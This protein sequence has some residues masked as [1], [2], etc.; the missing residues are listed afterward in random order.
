MNLNTLP[1]VAARERFVSTVRN[2]QVTILVG[3]TGS[4]KTILGPKMLHEA[5]LAPRGQIAVTEPRR[6]AVTS[7]TKFVRQQF[8]HSTNFGFQIR[9]VVDRRDDDNIVYMTTG[10]MLRE[11][12][13]DPQLRR[14]QIIFVDEAHERSL[15]SDLLLG[16]LKKV[17]DQDP[18]LKVVVASATIDA[19]KFSTFFGGA[20]IVEVEGFNFPVKIHYSPTNYNTEPVEHRVDGRWE[21]RP[22]EY[23]DV[24]VRR[25]QYVCDSS[26]EGDI[27][28]F[29]PGVKEINWVEAGITELR[30]PNIR[31][32]HMHGNLPVEKQNEAL[33]PCSARKI[34]IATN[35]AETS[36]TPDGLTVIIDSGLVKQEELENTWNGHQVAAL[37]VVEHSQAGCDQRAGRAG[38]TA[39][40]EC[41]RLFT[42]SSFKSRPKYT[43]PEIHRTPIENTLLHL[44]AIGEGDIEHFPF[45][46]PPDFNRVRDTLELLFELGAIDKERHLTPLGAQMAALPL[47]PRIAK[48]VLTAQKYNCLMEATILAAFLSTNRSVYI[49]AKDENREEAERAWD[50]VRDR[51]SDYMSY[52]KI[53]RLWDLEPDEVSQKNWCFNH[54]L[55]HRALVEVDMISDQICDLLRDI[56]IEVEPPA[57]SDSVISNP[58]ATAIHKCVLAA[59]AHNAM[60]STGRS[61]Y[62]HPAA[63]T[64]HIHRGSV[65]YRTNTQYVIAA[66]IGKKGKEVYGEQRTY[67][68]HVAPFKL[69]WIEEVAPHL[70]RP[71]INLANLEVNLSTHDF[72][73]MVKYRFNGVIS[74]GLEDDTLSLADAASYLSLE[75]RLMLNTVCRRALIAWITSQLDSVDR[76]N[77]TNER[78]ADIIYQTVYNQL[79]GDKIYSP[80]KTDHN[81]RLI[82]GCAA[83]TQRQLGP[84]LEVV[85]ARQEADRVRRAEEYARERAEIE[86]KQRR[87]KEML[88]PEII[89]LLGAYLDQ[90][91][92]QD[93]FRRLEQ[94]AFRPL[95]EFLDAASRWFVLRELDS[96]AATINRLRRIAEAKKTAKK[97]EETHRQLLARHLH[98]W[99]TLCPVCNHEI[100]LTKAQNGLTPCA[101]ED[102]KFTAQYRAKQQDH[103]VILYSTLNG[104]MVAELVAD[105]TGSTIKIQLHTP[106]TA[107]L[108]DSNQLDDI[109]IEEFAPPTAEELYRY[110][111]AAEIAAYLKDKTQ[112]ER[113]V[114]KGTA[115]KLQFRPVNTPRGLEWQCRNGSNTIYVV[116]PDSELIPSDNQPEFFC[117]TAR[118]PFAS[119]QGT[120]YVHATP[121]L[122]V[123]N[124]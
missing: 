2:N 39:P 64:V 35:V 112:A 43:E 102:E 106:G 32:F 99:Y 110:E 118:G 95:D 98:D 94:Y 9:H 34:I 13:E 84:A 36:V 10:I 20:P 114:D 90:F 54:F 50:L 23:I 111:H 101:C 107:T 124:Y 81:Q 15:D 3:K 53:F 93:D 48:L 11:M 6:V 74:I 82:L 89:T 121:F 37:K 72:A 55:L 42:E 52:L 67:M 19:N 18:T 27:L 123:M 109:E 16:C 7:A 66:G 122:A 68:D 70:I 79:F 85:Q 1:M 113:R 119:H 56:G 76:F 86:N 49:Y 38:R 28:I 91:K 108:T 61:E 59:F 33:E 40:G 120:K 5:G 100:D 41:Y 14:Y 78:R 77:W 8:G 26:R 30:I 103:V 45:L 87:L 29:V 63:G 104:H 69:E 96:A 73:I 115:K 83:E 51:Q 12:L 65:M 117:E 22:P 57:D 62:L 47:D 4:G 92:D 25:V 21:S 80:L 44:I 105:C 24:I 46:D 75:E 71:Q 116:K 58:D 31:I 97:R 60:K 17:L 88:T